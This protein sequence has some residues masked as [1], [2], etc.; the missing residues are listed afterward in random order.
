LRAWRGSF[1]GLRKIQFRSRLGLAMRQKPRRVVERIWWR[2][3]YDEP[4]ELPEQGVAGQVVHSGTAGVELGQCL[5]A[6]F[7][8]RPVV[9]VPPCRQGMEPGQVRERVG[10]PGDP[11]PSVGSRLRGPEGTP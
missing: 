5:D 1:A 6:L 8:D 10:A 3:W 2:S 9:V 7:D 4:G 11:G